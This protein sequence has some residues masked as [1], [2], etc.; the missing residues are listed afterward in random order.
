MT[1]KKRGKLEAR[2]WI[3]RDIPIDTCER[4]KHR[5]Y[6]DEYYERMSEIDASGNHDYIHFHKVCPKHNM[7]VVRT[8]TEFR[9]NE[10]GITKRMTTGRE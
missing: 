3:H 2:N 6:D 5:I 10:C 4:C 9:C 1:D 7:S 8:I